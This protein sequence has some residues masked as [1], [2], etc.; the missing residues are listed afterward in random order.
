MLSEKSISDYGKGGEEEWDSWFDN[1]EESDGFLICYGWNELFDKRKEF[2]YSFL[3]TESIFVSSFLPRAD[4]FPS[5]LSLEEW[6]YTL[7]GCRSSF[8]S[9][10]SIFVSSFLPRADFF[11]SFLSV[12]WLVF[13]LTFVLFYFYF[14]FNSSYFTFLILIFLFGNNLLFDILFLL[15]S[16]YF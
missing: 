6:A 14:I 4:F 15:F 7:T 8:L 9:T 1:K 3:S 12:W 5:F 16:N 2:G 10:E 11:P 13:V